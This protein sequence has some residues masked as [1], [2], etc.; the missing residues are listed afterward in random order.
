MGMNQHRLGNHH[1]STVDLFNAKQIQIKW[2]KS[3][4]KKNSTHHSNTLEWHDTK[5]SIIKSIQLIIAFEQ[6]SLCARCACV[7]KK[8]KSMVQIF[9]LNLNLIFACASVHCI[10][11]HDRDLLATYHL[12]SAIVFRSTSPALTPIRQLSNVTFVPNICAIAFL[13]CWGEER[14]NCDLQF[15]RPN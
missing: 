3:I 12:F 1:Q 14:Y 7:K 5:I 2:K 9:S 10:H 11:T 4:D 13:L 6:M 8:R 15:A